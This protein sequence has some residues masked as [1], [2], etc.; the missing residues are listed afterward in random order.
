MAEELNRSSFVP[1][2]GHRRDVIVRMVSGIGFKEGREFG[3][4]ADSE[5]PFRLRSPCEFNRDFG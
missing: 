1:D 5:F 2:L 4:W 3:H